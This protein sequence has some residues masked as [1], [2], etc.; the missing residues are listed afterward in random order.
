MKVLV[1]FWMDNSKQIIKL[2]LIPLI[3]V[4][5]GGIIVVHYQNLISER[6]IDHSEF[7]INGEQLR[8]DLEG[9]VANSKNN[10]INFPL[11][12]S[13]QSK[14]RAIVFAHNLMSSAKLN[15]PIEVYYAG[16]GWYTVSLG[17]YLEIEEA[18]TRVNYAKEVNIASDAFVWSSSN[19]ELVELDKNN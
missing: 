11:I 17:G 18:R 8:K 3:V 2:F 9:N 5:I 4:V 6:K 1:T 10:E 7:R 13:F 15:Y 14:E 12:G 16:N 19:M